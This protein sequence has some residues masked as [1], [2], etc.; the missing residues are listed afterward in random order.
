L[1]KMLHISNEKHF[2]GKNGKEVV[3]FIEK[4]D[5]HD[6]IMVLMDIKMP[7]MNGYEALKL[8][9]KIDMKIPV[10]A[11]TA[12]ALKHEEEAIM[13]KGFDDY[14]SKPVIASK[15]KEIVGRLFNN[16]G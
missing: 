1:I 3:D 6:N 5:S 14:I 11:V 8:I 13:A 4:L 10:I 9:K 2:W 16:Q 15:L 12:F 7:E